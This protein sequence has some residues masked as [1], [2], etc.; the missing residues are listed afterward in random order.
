MSCSAG[1]NA[2]VLTI[3][4]KPSAI[5]PLFQLLGRT[6]VLV[7]HPDDESA[8]V[9]LLQ[10]ARQATV[11][12]CT[13]GAP[14]SEYFWRRYGSR[15]AYAEIRSTEAKR[16]LAIVGKTDPEFL[17]HPQT[18]E[19][20]RDQELYQDLASAFAALLD[21]TENWQLEAIVA[22]AYEGGHPDHDACCLL[23]HLLGIELAVPVWELPLYYRAQSGEL[24]HQRFI[25][26]NGTEISVSLTSDELEKRRA[27]FAAYSSQPDA[28][29]FVNSV[30]EVYRPQFPYYFALAPHVGKLN[31]EAWGWPMTGIVLCQAFQSCLQLARR[32]KHLPTSDILGI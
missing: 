26:P 4:E 22:P 15:R 27:M 20:F 10:R 17:R 8:C 25:Q 30:V 9:A 2:A 31:Y 21:Q 23:A 28:S 14:A 19:G 11:L 18:H 16:S 24:V 5:E 1:T 7:A 12:F 13:D 29:K 3:P 6:L 32:P